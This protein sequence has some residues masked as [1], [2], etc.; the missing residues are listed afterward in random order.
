[1]NQAHRSVVV[2]AV[3]V[4]QDGHKR[5]QREFIGLQSKKRLVIAEAYHLFLMNSAIH[6]D[7][8]SACKLSTITADL[9]TFV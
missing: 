2:V 8:I 5:P 3:H 7:V 4:V 1:M 6:S 9:F